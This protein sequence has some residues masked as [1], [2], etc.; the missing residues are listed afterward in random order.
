LTPAEKTAATG[1]LT[2]VSTSGPLP[3]FKPNLPDKGDYEPRIRARVRDVIDAELADLVVG[4]GPAEH[5]DATKLFPMDR[6]TEIGNA[7]KTQTDKVFGSYATGPVFTPGVNLI[8][9]FED[10]ESRNAALAAG[11]D[12]AAALRKKAKGQVA[13][14][15]NTDQNGI[16]KINREHGAVPSRTTPPGP[17]LDSEFT[18][19]ERVRDDFAAS[20]ESNLLEIF[21]NWEGAQL[22]GQVFLQRFKKGSDLENRRMFWDTFQIMIHEYIHSLVHDD[23]HEYAKTTFGEQSEQYNT[24]IEGMDSVLT[25]VVW[26]NVAPNVQTPALRKQVEST[27]LAAAPFDPTT[28]PPVNNRRYPSYDQAL[29]LVNIVGIQNVFAAYFRG[30]VDLIGKL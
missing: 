30:R 18:I 16:L 15:L 21:R 4:K 8:D 3:T 9:Q 6:F 26:T 17:G 10:E 20:D 11:V 25:E 27:A 13:G 1:V 22:E 5:A 28:V 24:L 29:K 2:P 7:A 12:G 23:Y 19:L 14:I